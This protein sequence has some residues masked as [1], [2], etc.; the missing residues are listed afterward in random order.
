MKTAPRSLTGPPLCRTF[1]SMPGGFS[2][3][4]RRYVD[5]VRVAGAMCPASRG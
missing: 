5:M 4:T 2:G 1:L 3:T